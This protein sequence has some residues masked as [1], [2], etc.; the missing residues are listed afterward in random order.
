VRRRIAFAAAYDVL[1]REFWY[2]ATVAELLFYAFPFPRKETENVVQGLTLMGQAL[3]HGYSV[4]VFPEGMI[5]RS[6][7]LQPLKAGAGLV[8]TQ[9]MVPVVPVAL[10]GVREVVGSEGLWPKLGRQVTVRFGAPVM[11]SRAMVVAQATEEVEKA[12]RKALEKQ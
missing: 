8:A 3:D 11:V 5:S 6:G 1:Y 10:L 4:V 9:M 2:A 12:L 7:Q